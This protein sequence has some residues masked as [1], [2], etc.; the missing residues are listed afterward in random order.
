[1]CKKGPIIYFKKLLIYKKKDLKCLYLIKIIRLIK[2]DFFVCHFFSLNMRSLIQCVS[3]LYLVEGQ[4]LL[5]C[6][7][8]SINESKNKIV[9]D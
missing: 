9:R 8:H 5:N 2:I 7:I 4:N 6:M 1:M 3:Q